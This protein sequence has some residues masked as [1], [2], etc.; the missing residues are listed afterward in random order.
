MAAT[1]LIVMPTT[2][3][4]ARRIKEV[5]EATIP[6]SR[7]TQI[8]N[9]LDLPAIS[10]PLPGK[11]LPIGLQVIAAHGS[12]RAL[13][14]SACAAAARRPD[15]PLWAQR[16]RSTRCADGNL[17]WLPC[18]FCCSWLTADHVPRLWVLTSGVLSNATLDR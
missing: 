13:S 5:D 18:T 14:A 7:F 8:A 4:Q 1:P 10:L 3:I 6:L 2:P 15:G 9:H 17:R 16:D 11:R 12:D